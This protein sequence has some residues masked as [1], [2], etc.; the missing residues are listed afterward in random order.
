MIR[1]VSP[2]VA[3]VLLVVSM[4]L[5]RLVDELTIDRVLFL[6]LD[7]DR[8]GLVHLIGRNDAYTFFS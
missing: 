8:N 4:V 5:L 3:L 2:N 7:S 6:P 1:T